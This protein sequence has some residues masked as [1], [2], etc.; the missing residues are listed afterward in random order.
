MPYQINKAAATAVSIKMTG[1]MDVTRRGMVLV[2]DA[3]VGGSM[4]IWFFFAGFGGFSL[5]R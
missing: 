1:I 3:E 5:R 4:T 2:I